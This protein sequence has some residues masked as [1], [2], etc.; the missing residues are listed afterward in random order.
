M[1]NE[2]CVRSLAAAAL[3]AAFSTNG[4]AQA[5][6]EVEPN[7][8]YTSAQQLVI[9]AD[10]TA[11]V[12][13]VMGVAS[14]TPV[15]DVDFYSFTAKAGDVVTINIDGGAHGTDG[16]GLDSIIALFGP[17]S[18]TSGFEPYHMYGAN[19]NAS[20]DAGSVFV[21]N[22]LATGAPMSLDSRLDGIQ[23]QQDGTYWVGVSS[24]LRFFADINS[25]MNP[26][27]IDMNTDGTYTLIV[28]GVTP[29]AP[30]APPPVVTP[31]PPAPAP[32]L[33]VTAINIEI[34]PGSNEI[35]P[36]NPKAKGSIP[37][38][39]L[40]SPKFNAAQVDQSSLRFG[41]KGTEASLVRCNNATDLNRD[42]LPD[43]LCH[44]DNQKAGFQQGDIDGIVTG[45]AA[46][47]PF[48]GEGLLKVVPGK[49]Q[50]R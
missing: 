15:L 24:S 17:F 47:Q 20:P 38:V 42:G 18:G 13:A 40:S 22:D 46:G 2:L 8:A 32:T 43:L 4:F 3:L 36:I 27:Y 16:T 49:A 35:S 14:G 39:L 21:Y 9:G 41:R 6:S 44:F 31:P 45:T 12:N 19:D 11:T 48:R 5:V 37:V 7:D 33:Q 23:L 50:R 1:K 28:S 30:V 25:L 34:K 29:P 10:G 26:T